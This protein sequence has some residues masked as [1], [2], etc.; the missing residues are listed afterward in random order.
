MTLN[1]CIKH[2]VRG[3]EQKIC[4]TKNPHGSW[5]EDDDIGECDH[6]GCEFMKGTKPISFDYFYF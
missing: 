3:Y 5:I 2:Y 1:K 4:P 6:E